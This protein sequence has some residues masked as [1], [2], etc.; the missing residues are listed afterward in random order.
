MLLEAKAS[1]TIKSFGFTFSTIPSSI[2]NVSI[3]VVPR[4]PGDIA[5]IGLVPSSTYSGIYLITCLVTSILDI[6][7]GPKE[8]GV[9]YSL[10]SPTTKTSSEDSICSLISI[11]N[12]FAKAFA[13]SSISSSVAI[14]SFFTSIVT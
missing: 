5:L 13:A 2:S 3:P 12:S 10:P 11:F 9:T 7:F 6:T 4:T 14:F 8:S 1:I